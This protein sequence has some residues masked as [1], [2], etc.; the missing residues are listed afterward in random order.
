MLVVKAVHQV[1]CLEDYALVLNVKLCR[2]LEEPVYY[3]SAQV[4]SNMLLVLHEG[5]KLQLVLILE[6]IS[7]AL[8]AVKLEE[9][10]L[11]RFK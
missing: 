10:G 2:Y 6:H 8:L 4:P 11:F 9:A 7:E 1:D 5:L 3:A